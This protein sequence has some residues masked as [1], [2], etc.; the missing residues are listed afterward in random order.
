MVLI[1]TEFIYSRTAHAMTPPER[2][3]VLEGEAQIP[4]AALADHK[5]HR[6]SLAVGGTEVRI[7]AIL[8]STDTV[9]VAL[10]GRPRQHTSG[11]APGLPR[12]G[13]GC[14]PDR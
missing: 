1:S 9:R 8:D 3:P 10:D 11:D 7:I 2:L 13:F 4:T 12:P 5:L 14:H 6:Y